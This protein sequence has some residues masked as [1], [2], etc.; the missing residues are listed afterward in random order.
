MNNRKHWSIQVIKKPFSTN[1]NFCPDGN[2]LRAR[3]LHLGYQREIRM[4]EQPALRYS[5]LVY[6]V[7]HFKIDAALS[8]LKGKRRQNVF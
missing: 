5:A 6:F 8:S 4:Q 7:L 1:S 3:G 2:L